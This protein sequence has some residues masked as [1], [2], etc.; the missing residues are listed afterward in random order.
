MIIFVAPAYDYCKNDYKKGRM[1]VNIIIFSK[2][3]IIGY[4]VAIIL[5]LI[6]L[7][8]LDSLVDKTMPTVNPIYIGDTKEKA[9]ALM[10]NVDWGNE[11]IPEILEILD[12]KE[13][14]ATF[15]ISGKFANKFPDL[16]K[17]IA[18]DG[19]EIGNHGY[20]HPHPNKISL[21]RNM[22]EIIDTEKQFSNLNISISKIFAPPYGEHEKVVL[23]AADKL[24]YKTIM[25]TLDTIDWKDPLPG[26]I[27]KRILSKVDNGSMILMHPKECTL[28]AL[29]SLIDSMKN[30]DFSFRTV[31]E[32]IK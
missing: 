31:T 5:I 1:Y 26:T 2:K 20:Y 15:F 4:L 30:D 28:Q 19:H 7:F 11:I 27:L 18:Q 21:E 10:F 22:K 3:R 17:E 12:N 8:I 9:A 29:P 16:T 23:Q 24:G 32:I 13:V 14:K 25:W 6:G